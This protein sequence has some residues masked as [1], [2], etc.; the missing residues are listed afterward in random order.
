WG[1]IRS[2]PPFSATEATAYS[3][4]PE[5]LSKAL[6]AL[7]PIVDAEPV[8]DGSTPATDRPSTEPPDRSRCRRLVRLFSTTMSVL[9][10]GFYFEEESDRRFPGE[11]VIFARPPVWGRR[12]H[13]EAV[14]D[15]CCR[16]SEDC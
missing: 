9:N 7:C 2:G 13:R 5:D 8:S 16:A 6:Q 15:P 4:L 3:R 10:Q 1:S 14:L 12:A 11:G